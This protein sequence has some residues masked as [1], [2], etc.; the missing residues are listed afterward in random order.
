[1]SER[2]P[3]MREITAEIAARHGADLNLVLHTRGQT[4]V[5]PVRVEAMAACYA[6]GRF[7]NMQVARRFNL[8][9][10][11][12]VVAARRRWAALEARRQ[13]EAAQAARAA[14]WWA[15]APTRALEAA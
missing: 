4:P 8:T 13:A 5:S 1:M 6:T 15:A 14:A 10:H 11:T 3:T 7:T 12:S 9:D 2:L